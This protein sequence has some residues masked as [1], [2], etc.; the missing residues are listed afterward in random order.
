MAPARL[1]FPSCA[2]P[3]LSMRKPSTQH[4]PTKTRKNSGIIGKAQSRVKRKNTRRDFWGRDDGGGERGPRGGGG[5]L[6]RG[7]AFGEPVGDPLHRV[8]RH[9]VHAVGA[10]VPPERANRRGIPE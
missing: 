1:P 5:P 10:A 4:Q 8:A 2:R 9:V 7:R 3:F 6:P